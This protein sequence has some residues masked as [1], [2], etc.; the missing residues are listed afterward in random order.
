M[1]IEEQLSLLVKFSEQLNSALLLLDE[2]GDT[3]LSANARAKA[4]LGV[5]T[6]V[7][8]EGGSLFG[9]LK[10][11][12]LQPL[13]FIAPKEDAASFDTR[14]YI[15]QRKQV[16]KLSVQV[17]RYGIGDREVLAVNCQ[18]V[19]AK[20][21]VEEQ[22]AQLRSAIEY[23]RDGI[24]I[25]TAD[26]PEH[27]QIVYA[28]A[29]FE[30]LTGYQPSAA[31]GKDLSFLPI[32]D[33]HRSRFDVLLESIKRGVPYAFECQLCRKDGSTLW[34]DWHVSPVFDDDRR[35]VNWVMVTR[36]VTIKKRILDEMTRQKLSYHEQ[37]SQAMLQAQDIERQRIAEELHDSVGHNL[38]VMRMHL[39]LF[40]EKIQALD[41]QVLVD[42]VAELD[43]I[44]TET[45][46]EV[47]NTS[48]NL[49]PSLLIDFGLGA[50]VRSLFS[51]LD[52]PGEISV[53]AAVDDLGAD[54]P[55]GTQLS[56]YRI[57]QELANNTL[58]HAGATAISISLSRDDDDLLLMRY[59]DN[60]TGFDVEMAQSEA[61]GLGV[62]NML[63][64]ASVLQGFLTFQSPA[65]GGLH[66]ELRIPNVSRERQRMSS[67]AG[68]I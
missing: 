61:G 40:Q 49:S 45:T 24:I 28:N 55:A 35:L 21:S 30:R 42:T 34:V 8:L 62:K 27:V 41:D 20:S 31:I 6:D 56:V 9:Y 15:A 14:V 29:S 53:S 5:A 64:R 38:S 57:I 23:A 36:D 43:G 12:D 68:L 4:L 51:R 48:R 2:D 47:R 54:I 33:H 67:D 7:E 52:A 11:E 18:Q 58:K 65:E 39:S 1:A 63:T 50:A 16:L 44:L 17:G 46:Q 37:L 19:D 59:A 66:A 3:I 10:T 13:V 60:G 22:F 25:T 26:E 32:A